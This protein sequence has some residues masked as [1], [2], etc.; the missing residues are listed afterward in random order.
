MTS[1]KQ[2]SRLAANETAPKLVDR[3]DPIV[4]PT[5]VSSPELAADQ[6][7]T[8]SSEYSSPQWDPIAAMRRRRE[9][10]LRLPPMPCGCRDPLS[11]Q[12]AE[13]R[14]RRWRSVA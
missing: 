5:G 1:Q 7:N 6:P 4:A 14:C 9:A 10:A 2:R 12:H 3:T 13:G 11:T 8:D